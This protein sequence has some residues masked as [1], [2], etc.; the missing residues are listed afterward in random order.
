MSNVLPAAVRVLNIRLRNSDAISDISRSAGV[1][2]GYRRHDAIHAS[3][4]HR[5]KI[6][7]QERDGVSHS[8]HRASIAVLRF[9]T[10]KWP[11]I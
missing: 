10:T 7:S 3:W 4:G 11:S 5:H 6:S 2:S 8:K 9:I 1:F